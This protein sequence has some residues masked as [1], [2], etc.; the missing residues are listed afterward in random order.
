LNTYKAVRGFTLIELLSVMLIFSLLALMSYRG[1]GAV[2]DSREHVSREAEKWQSVALFLARFE[3][4]VH[5]ASPRLARTAA[6]TAPAWI[7]APGGTSAPLLAFSRFA[8]VDGLDTAQRLGYGLNQ[9]RE[10]ETWLWPTVDMPPDT[11]PRRYAVLRDVAKFELQYMNAGL[12]WVRSWPGTGI[13]APIPR[14]VQLR[15][16]LGSG[17]EI[18]RVYAV[19]P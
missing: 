11:V 10:I 12:G 14:A 15:V 2:L 6:G 18:V 3:R 17:E 19:N 16:V 5:L 9:N 4:D 13:G 8:A 1:L 7:G